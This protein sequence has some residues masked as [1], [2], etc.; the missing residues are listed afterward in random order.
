[1]FILSLPVHEESPAVV[2]TAAEA[3]TLGMTPVRFP[4]GGIQH[5]ILQPGVT[6]H[7]QHQLLSGEDVRLVP[8]QVQ[9]DIHII[10]T[11]LEQI[12]CVYL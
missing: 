12:T 5:T 6:Q 8:S 7:T 1:M 11:I 10:V 4:L 3:D 9:T 2:V